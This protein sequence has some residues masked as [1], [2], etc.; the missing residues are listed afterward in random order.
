LRI[1]I[2]Y[3]HEA[4]RKGIRSCLSSRIDRILCG[5]AQDGLSGHPKTGLRQ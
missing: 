2:V 5:E 1:P 4:V 3:D